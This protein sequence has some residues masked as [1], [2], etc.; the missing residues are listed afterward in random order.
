MGVRLNLPRLPPAL[1]G[2]GDLA[3]NVFAVRN[4]DDLT[5]IWYEV[6]FP[7]A[8]VGRGIPRKGDI[9]FSFML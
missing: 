7:V 3:P 5:R 4:R 6:C 9:G 2:R 8:A 1:S